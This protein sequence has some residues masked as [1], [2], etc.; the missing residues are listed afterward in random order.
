MAGLQ[1]DFEKERSNLLAMLNR[2]S[3]GTIVLEKHPVFVKLTKD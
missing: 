1:K 2:F 3:P